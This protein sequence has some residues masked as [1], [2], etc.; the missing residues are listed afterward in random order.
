MTD[1]TLTQSDQD[2]FVVFAVHSS[3]GTVQHQ[4]RPDEAPLI[5]GRGETAGLRIREDVFSREHARIQLNGDEIVLIDLDSRNGLKVNGLR[6]WQPTRL[7]DGDEISVA[8]I[9]IRVDLAH[10]LVGEQLKDAS[11]DH[12]QDDVTRDA[13]GSD[14]H[15]EWV[16]VTVA[17]G[18]QAAFRQSFEAPSQTEDRV[19]PITQGRLVLGREPRCDIM[20]DSLMIS[21][22]HAEVISESGRVLIHDLNSTNGTAVNGTNIIRRTE[23]KQGDRVTIGPF[24]IHFDGRAFIIEPPRLGLEVRV[25][26]LTREVKDMQTGKPL[27]LLDE[28]SFTIEPRSFVGLL[29]PSGCGKSTLMDALN[30]RRRGTGGCV[31]FNEIDL[32]KQFDAFKAGIGYVPQEVIFHD[33]LPL[34]E[35]LRYASQLRLSADVS[36]EEID[37]NIMRVLEIVGLTERRNTVIRHLSGGQKKRVSIAIELLSDP[38][39]LFLD[40]VTSG[41]DLGTEKEMMELFRKLADDGK[42]VICITHFLESLSQCDKLVCLMRGKLVFDGKP[43]DMKQHFEIEELREVYGLE[44]KASPDDWR[45]RFLDT[46]QGKTLADQA[47]LQPQGEERSASGAKSSVFDLKEF[48]LQLRVLT[49]RYVRLLTLDRKMLGLLLLLAPVVGVMLCIYAQSVEVTGEFDLPVKDEFVNSEIADSAFRPPTKQ[50]IDAEL[51]RIIDETAAYEE[52]VADTA[53]NYRAY[54]TRQRI[55]LYGSVLAAL[56]LS[57]F[58]S[59]QEIVKELPIYF[60]ERFVKLQLAPYLLS[61]LFPLGVLGAAQAFLLLITIHILA[62]IDAGAFVGQFLVLFLLSLVGTLLGLVISAGVP[63]GKESA[64]IAVLLM[65]AVVIPQVLFSGG[66]GPLE[67]AAEWIGKSL[68]A[69]YWGLESLTSHIDRAPPDA[70]VYPAFTGM[71]ALVGTRYW[72]GIFVLLG[73]CIALGLILVA[74]MLQKDG[75]EAIR[76]LRAGMKQ[77]KEKA[78]LA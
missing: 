63:G 50:A 8:D 66:L 1:G 47:K 22:L 11:P 30:G 58:A 20:L 14:G 45:Q 56:L 18:D 15:G 72:T 53:A 23:L 10:W 32:Y 44:Q 29:G 7:L 52:Q 73:H 62:D 67:G 27:R 57:M 65:I 55:L 60:H 46:P 21:R 35:A 43:Q 54:Y 13:Q 39:I 12:G 38:D 68:V 2:R 64:N 26:G 69:C 61:K 17:Q 33:T 77:I 74:F 28:V 40:E 36:S 16:D 6:V 76:K 71:D 41:L 24:Q 31:R 42:T 3:S 34:G 51:N 5:M 25:Q 75:P 4:W 78:G 59:V 70:E 37:R 19:I 48:V 9:V 49:Q